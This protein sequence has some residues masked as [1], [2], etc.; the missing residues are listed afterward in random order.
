[1]KE[2]KLTTW[3]RIQL[4]RCV[5]PT[6][7]TI[8]DVAKHLRVGGILD[9]SEEEKELVG[10]KETR[11]MTPQGLV[12]RPTWDESMAEHL[13]EIAMEDADFKHLQSL[14]AKYKAWPTSQFT[15]DLHEKIKEAGGK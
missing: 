3:E 7:P 10:W 15:I 4:L 2:M 12:M 8:E 13:F 1:M 6:A 5:P 9:L 14:M 11:M